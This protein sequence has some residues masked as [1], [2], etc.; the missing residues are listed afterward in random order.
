MQIEFRLK[1][2]QNRQVPFQ[3]D[4][5]RSKIFKNVLHVRLVKSLVAYYILM[6]F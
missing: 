3:I 6:I 5:T 1:T 4:R 2:I